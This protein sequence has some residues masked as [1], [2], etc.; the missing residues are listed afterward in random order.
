MRVFDENNFSEIRNL[1]LKDLHSYVENVTLHEN[2]P[3]DVREHFE[4]ARNL[5]VYSWFY[6][7]FNVAAQ[8][9]AFIT[10]EFAL[11]DKFRIIKPSINISVAQKPEKYDKGQTLSPLLK[12]AIEEKL[13]TDKGFSHIKSNQLEEETEFSNQLNEKNELTHYCK[14][15]CDVFP[16]MRNKLAHGSNMLYGQGGEYIKICAELINQLFDSPEAIKQ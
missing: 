2:V 3:L 9:Y 14:I 1:T 13:I 4:M 11:K 15:L 8:L 5:Y 10:L 12:R 6:Y 16:N 7:P